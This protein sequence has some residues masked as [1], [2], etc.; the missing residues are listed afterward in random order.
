MSQSL[1]KSSGLPLA[2]WGLRIS[3]RQQTHFP[4]SPS[5]LTQYRL[6]RNRKAIRRTTNDPVKVILLDIEHRKELILLTF[7]V[8]YYAM[9]VFII[10]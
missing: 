8:R 4:I 2:P 1:R 9:Y 3:G 10:M 7:L 5:V 6:W